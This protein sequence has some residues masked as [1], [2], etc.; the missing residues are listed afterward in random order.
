[1]PPSSYLLVLASTTLS[2]EL[3]DLLPSFPSQQWPTMSRL[4]HPP[5]GVTRADE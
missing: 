2:S 4:L 1:M 3:I 5:W